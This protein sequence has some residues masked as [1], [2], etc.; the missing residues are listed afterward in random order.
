MTD[1]SGRVDYQKA[2]K[3]IRSVLDQLKKDRKPLTARD[4]WKP[5]QKQTNLRDAFLR[6]E[7][8]DYLKSFARFI[9]KARAGESQSFL[10]EFGLDEQSAFVT[11]QRSIRTAKGRKEET[12]YQGAAQRAFQLGSEAWARELLHK[13]DPTKFKVKDIVEGIRRDSETALVSAEQ[14]VLFEY[15]ERLLKSA[16]PGGTTGNK[17]IASVLRDYRENCKEFARENPNGTSWDSEALI[18]TV[19]DY[20]SQLTE[21]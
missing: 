18:S 11:L 13:T 9:E 4:I 5:L 8:T 14:L 6:S 12:E 7:I 19:Q 16:V 1:S 2:K 3:T 21:K 10:K 15:G 17:E 20:Y